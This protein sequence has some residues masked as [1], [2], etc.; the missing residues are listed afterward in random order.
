M[1]AARGGGGLEQ[2]RALLEQA[3]DAGT[4]HGYALIE[5]RAIAELSTLG[6]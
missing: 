3:R 5:H 1:L 2:A 6:A 4:T